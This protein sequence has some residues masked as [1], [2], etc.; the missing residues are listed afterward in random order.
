LLDW[1]NLTTVL[2]SGIIVPFQDTSVVE[3]GERFYRAV[4]LP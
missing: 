4:T 1:Q 3:A 2:A